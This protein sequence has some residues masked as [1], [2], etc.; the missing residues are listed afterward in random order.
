M[1]FPRVCNGCDGKL[2][3]QSMQE[4]FTP[5]KVIEPSVK[6]QNHEVLSSRQK[7]PVMHIKVWPAVCF[8]NSTPTMT[9]LILLLRDTMN[10]SCI[11]MFSSC[12]EF[13]FYAIKLEF[14]AQSTVCANAIFVHMPRRRR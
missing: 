11:K 12:G 1:I 7:K 6:P 14:S 9:L 4:P 13:I 10:L 2:S 8:V 3:P 5:T